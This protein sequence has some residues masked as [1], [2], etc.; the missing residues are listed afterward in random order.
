MS[1]TRQVDFEP[2]CAAAPVV[3]MEEHW[4]P[5]S[6]VEM[7][8]HQRDQLMYSTRGA[9]HVVTAT[10]RWILPP[11]R[12]IWISGGTDH[13]FEAKRPV[14]LTI[15]YIEPG[16]PGSPRWKGCAVV[17]VSALVRELISACAC[18]PWDYRQN[19]RAGRLT[20]VLLEQLDAL[21]QAP[22]DLPE[23]KDPRAVRLAQWLKANPADRTP[24]TMLAPGFGGSVK[25]IERLFA[26]ETGMSFGGWRVRLRM[27]TALEQ[28][29]HGES[30]ANVAHGVG[31]ESPSSFIAA[32]RTAFGTTPSRYFDVQNVEGTSGASAE[33]VAG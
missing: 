11:T 33:G 30:V 8:S 20:R 19:S 22:L 5:A 12:A 9:M 26:A 4:P 13:G 6:Q 32:F 3:G 7:H 16:A 27:M 2:D 17:N 15:L 31:Y 23:P 24:L 1:L 28:L 10:G 18:L 25:T 29:A 21:Q 14:D